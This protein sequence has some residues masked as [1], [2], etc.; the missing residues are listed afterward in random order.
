MLY[1]DCRVELSTM[2]VSLKIQLGKRDVPSDEEVD[3]GKDW[4]I[5]AAVRCT[6]HNTRHI[7]KHL[8]LGDSQ[9]HSAIH[10]APGMYEI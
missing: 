7:G 1:R 6:N 4:V 9:R 3:W 8:T 2:A 10:A 5:H